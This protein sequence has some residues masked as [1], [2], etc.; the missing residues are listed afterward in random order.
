MEER[1]LMVQNKGVQ[2]LLNRMESHPDEF[3]GL[4]GLNSGRWSWVMD[5]VVTRMDHKHGVMTDFER[6]QKVRTPLPFL[7]DAE[8]EALYDKFMSIHGDNFTKRVMYDLLQD[9]QDNSFLSANVASNITIAGATG[10]HL[11]NN[12]RFSTAGRYDI[13]NHAE[14]SRMS[15]TDP[16]KYAEIVQALEEYQKQKP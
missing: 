15:I 12:V 14:L 6:H 16:V 1:V 5:P 10:A 11:S 7:T 13:W 8:V 4:G 3:T 2:I 9:E